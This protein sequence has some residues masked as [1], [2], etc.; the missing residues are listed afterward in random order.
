MGIIASRVVTPISKARQTSAY[1]T[2]TPKGA[3]P[4]QWKARQCEKNEVGTVMGG[5]GHDKKR[6]LMGMLPKFGSAITV[7]AP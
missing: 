5:G 6:H 1:A 7:K 3:R 4:L 2:Q